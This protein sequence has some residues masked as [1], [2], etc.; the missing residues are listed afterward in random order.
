MS[1][2]YSQALQKDA[3]RQGEANDE[4]DKAAPPGLAPSQHFV[5]LAQ[6][7][8]G[9][10]GARHLLCQFQVHDPDTMAPRPTRDRTGRPQGDDDAGKVLQA[11]GEQEIHDLVDETEACQLQVL[12]NVEAEKGGG[13]KGIL[14]L[15]SL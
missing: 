12:V 2:S 11:R 9:V 8:D 10:P 3:D 14:V 5:A 1:L 7:T 6:G 4:A 15:V 13:A